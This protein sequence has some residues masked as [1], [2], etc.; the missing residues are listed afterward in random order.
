MYR[1]RL[2]LH[3]GRNIDIMEACPKALGILAMVRAMNPQIVAVVEVALPAELEAM[4]RASH[5]GTALLATVHARTP[6]DLRRRPLLSS[7]MELGIFQRTVTIE[8][9]EG[10]RRYRVEAG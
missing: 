10:G 5:T 6:D 8:R 7:M 1:C 3:V 9:V 4:E 2:Q